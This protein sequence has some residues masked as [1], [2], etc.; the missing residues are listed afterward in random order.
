MTPTAP[1]ASTVEA[2]PSETAALTGMK[3]AFERLL[4][5]GIGHRFPMMGAAVGLLAECKG[6]VV[7]TGMGKSGV[8]LRKVAATGYWE[9]TVA[10]FFESPIDPVPSAEVLRELYTTYRPEVIG[11]GMGQ[12][13]VRARIDHAAQVGLFVEMA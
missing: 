13:I 10:R 5:F 1:P 8:V 2:S 6:R 3:E 4:V 12:Y 7:C 9:E 11:L